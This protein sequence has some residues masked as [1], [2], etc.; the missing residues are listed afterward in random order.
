MEYTKKA[1]TGILGFD[2]VIDSLRIGDNVVF[3]VNSIEEYKAFVDPFIK[4]SLEDNRKLIYMRYADHAPLIE[5]PKILEKTKVYTIDAFHGFEAF[6]SQVHDIITKEG[7][8]AFY[9][10]DCLSDLLSAWATDLMIGNFFFVTCPY[11]YKMKTIAY[12]SLIKNSTSYQTV[13]TIRETTQLMLDVYKNMDNIYIHPLKVW[14][15]F[16]PTMFLPHLIEEDR[17]TPIINSSE[18]AKIFADAAR[19]GVVSTSRNLD[20]WEWNFI[21]AE[22]LNNKINNGEK[23]ENEVIERTKIKL[24]NLIISKEQR[25]LKLAIKHFSLSDILEIKSRLIGSGYIGGK[26][27]GMLLA[28]KILLEDKSI[29]WSRYL[30]QHDSFYIGSDVF[31]TYLVQNNLWEMKIYQKDIEKYFEYGKELKVKILNGLVPENIKE[32]LI[33]MLEY[34]GQYPI[35]VRSSSLLE[36]S[37][38]NAFAGKYESVFCINS[39]DISERYKK[40]EE[41]VKMIYAS[42]MN[43]DALVYRYLRGLSQHDEQM[44]LLVQR[45]SGTYH[46]KYFFPNCAG[47]GVSYNTYVWKDI[48]NPEQGMLRLVMGLGTRAVNRLEGDYA[49]MIAL[50]APTLNIYSSKDEIRE[51]SQHEIDVLD[52]MENKLKSTSIQ[53]IINSKLDINM[54]LLGSRDSEAENRLKKLGMEFEE[55]WIISF[56]GLIENTKFIDIMTKMMKTIERYYNNPVDIEFTVNFS[57]D[58][59]F[60]INLVQCRPLQVKG[61][62]AETKQ[63]EEPQNSKT[64][65]NS[66]GNFMG[67]SIYQKVDLLIYVDAYE[68]HLLNESD[69]HLV[70][71][72][73]GKIN[74]YLLRENKCIM[75]MGPG[76][77][78]STTPSLGVPVRF[79]EIANVNVLAEYS[80]PESGYMPDL[81]FGSHFFQD[82]VESRIFYVALFKEKPEV[83][84]NVSILE[85]EQNIFDEILPDYKRLKEVLKVYDISRGKRS[86]IISSNIKSQKVFCFF[87]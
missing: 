53:E 72:A 36:D 64:I 79:S 78:G 24:S 33:R 40:L 45:V 38:G 61:I 69:K 58:K 85:D 59:E 4:K 49:K 18:A 34:F 68:Y 12:F 2:T 56:D 63:I 35:I 25:I 80:F 17:C 77:W 47:V 44:S 8:G 37:F 30:E 54:K 9:I 3:R 55:K 46:D 83:S 22:E 13:A 27:L 23:I 19:D 76:R 6:S 74:R 60:L 48:M 15:R 84:I 62:T 29:E 86:I 81:S 39:G 5:N 16:T 32:K 26:A 20:R 52:I 51:F 14:K 21:D 10:F 11:L 70:A 41:A 82:L 65:F 71:R 75:L 42:T 57:N 28:R 50:D 73:I 1:S 7:F 31:Y 87:D 66:I 67:G 43:E